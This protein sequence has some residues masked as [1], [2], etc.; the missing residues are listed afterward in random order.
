MRLS[1]EN[2]LRMLYG[3][4]GAWGC[5]KQLCYKCIPSNELMSNTEFQ[6]EP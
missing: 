1:G 3:L 6:L 2:K 4:C 5:D